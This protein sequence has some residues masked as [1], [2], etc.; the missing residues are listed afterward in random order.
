MAAVGEGRF[1]IP[2]KCTSCAQP[3]GRSSSTKPGKR[4]RP[5]ATS[6]PAYRRRFDTSRLPSVSTANHADATARG[7]RPYVPLGFSAIADRFGLQP[8]CLIARAFDGQPECKGRLSICRLVTLVFG[9]SGAAAG[10]CRSGMPESAPRAVRDPGHYSKS[11][12]G[13]PKV[14]IQEAI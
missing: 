12:A 10:N 4:T 14:P 8:A 1:R 5:D 3:A 6:G 2:A 7:L 11:K 9:G 13:I